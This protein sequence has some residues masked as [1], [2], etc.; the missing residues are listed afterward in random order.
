MS[1]LPEFLWHYCGLE[2]AIAILDNETFRLTSI[3]HL[4]DGLEFR[5]LQQHAYILL[6]ASED[7]LFDI[8]LAVSTD[9]FKHYCFCMSAKGDLLSQW[10]GYAKEG[11]GV[12]LAI[13]PR[14]FR[15]VYTDNDTWRSNV[16]GHAMELTKVN[17][18]HHDHLDLIQK[19]IR[20]LR[21]DYPTT[22]PDKKTIQRASVLFQLF[23]VKES[24]RCKNPAFFQEEEWRLIYKRIDSESPLGTKNQLSKLNVR[25]SG[26]TLVPFYEY[27]FPKYEGEAAGTVADDSPILGMCLGPNVNSETETTLR[28]FL[29][30]RGYLNNPKFFIEHSKATYRVL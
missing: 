10:R 4:N 5:W 19:E 24:A 8:D 12:S 7:P 25:V 2:S 23:L 3:S 28:M 14:C 6:N 29:K 21:T 22:T 15:F 30:D 27:S 11:Y 16:T 20:S 18:N 26:N 17:Y 9:A 13:N 1:E